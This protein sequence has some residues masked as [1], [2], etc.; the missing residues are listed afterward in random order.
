[1]KILVTG[2][3]GFIGSNLV[4][5]LI[6]NHEVVVFDNGFR[7]GFE[8]I[9]EKNDSLTI[10]EGDVTK[11]DDWNVLPLDVD[12]VFHLAAINGT[13]FFYEIP[14]TVL[15]VNIQG[16]MNFFKW[17]PKSNVKNFFFAGSSEVYGYPEK[18]PTTENS[19]LS[20]PDPK[21]PRFS[22]SSS[23][24]LGE[25]LSVNFAKKIGINYTIGRFHNVYGPNMGFEHVIPEFIRKCVRNESF[26]VQGDGTESR[27]FCYID[28][29]IDALTI[30]LDNQDA[31]NEIFNI[32][33]SIETKIFELIK[34][35]EKIH[36]SEIKPQF[37]EFANGGTKRRVPDLE[38]I[39]KLGYKPRVSLLD[40]LTYA[41]NWYSNYYKKNE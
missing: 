20:I 5:K 31:R 15:E 39:T 28:D 32:G 38:K 33:N 6:L 35:I 19:L 41:Y 9:Q 30:L 27:A 17:L 26:T 40:G 29:A 21:N 1:M 12:Y 37:I 34:N 36:G 8:N 7:R 10:I 24:I 14:T 13:K 2:G 18:F 25:I 11:T 23:K 3:A 16:T 22:Y 4:K